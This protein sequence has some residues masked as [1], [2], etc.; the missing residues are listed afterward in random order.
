MGCLVFLARF[1]QKVKIAV[2]L[3]LKWVRK[4]K[5]PPSTKGG[6]HLALVAIAP[7]DPKV[8]AALQ[9]FFR[10]ANDQISQLYCWRILLMLDKEREQALEVLGKLYNDTSVIQTTVLALESYNILAAL[11]PKA[12]PILSRTKDPNKRKL[13]RLYVEEAK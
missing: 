13:L 8:R 2:P 5:I 9:N 12:K 10:S 6:I 4:E 11:G 3:L 1:R 7:Q